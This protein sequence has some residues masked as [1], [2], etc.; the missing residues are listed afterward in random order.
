MESALSHIKICEDF[1]FS[2]LVISLKSSNVLMMIEAYRQLARTVDYPLHL[3]VTEAGP[4]WSGTIRSAVGI[5]T[6]LAEGIGDTIRG[7]VD[8]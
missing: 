8:R 6:L 3:G 1:H 5:G 2:D 4:V 7:V